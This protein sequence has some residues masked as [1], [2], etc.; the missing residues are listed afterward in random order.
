M[1]K[2]QFLWLLLALLCFTATGV[3]GVLMAERAQQQSLATVETMLNGLFSQEEEALLLP[4]EPYVA[5]LNVEGSIMSETVYGESFDLDYTLDCI[6]TYMAD[7]NNVGLLLY[8]NSPGGELNASDTL[9]YKLM[10]Y[11]LETG[12]PIYCYF[13]DYA[14]SGGYYVAMPADEICANRNSMCVNIG[15]YIATYNFSGLF[16]KA[17]VEE[18]IFRSSENKGIGMPGTPWT[19]EQKE[20]YQSL[21]DIHYQQFLEVVAEGRGM[22]VEQV[23]T[24]DDGREMLAVQALEAG[25][26][27]G[28][29]R[30]E[31]YEA[32]VLSHFSEDTVLYEPE[33]APDPMAEL[34]GYLDSRLP[35]SDSQV[36]MDFAEKHG[37]MV[38]MAYAD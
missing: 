19:E 34:F 7:E 32:A 3:T 20:I 16:E 33:Y 28:I 10:D 6:E 15:V 18:V 4:A 24:L 12:R 13:D 8:V 2:K 38:V 17:G 27:D 22:T 26:I 1:T 30:L 14:C 23:R 31:E 37:G 5:R 36:W 25:F 11:K 9:Y 21:V 29:C 35:R